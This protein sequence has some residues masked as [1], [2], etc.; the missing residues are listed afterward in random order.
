MTG[1]SVTGVETWERT[2]IYVQHT[3]KSE[4]LIQKMRC[5]EKG[6]LDT[7]IN[8]GF[9]FLSV[10]EK[11]E[12]RLH[13]R[14]LQEQNIWIYGKDKKTKKKKKTLDGLLSAKS[15]AALQRGVVTFGID[16]VMRS[17]P[18]LVLLLIGTRRMRR[19]WRRLWPQFA[20]QVVD[21]RSHLR[22]CWIH[23]S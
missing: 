4:N 22:L 6:S 15:T 2:K 11:I 23:L 13:V 8:Q 21:V 16:E 19:W 5:A 3:V 7:H 17:I 1:A 9:V 10:L 14:L 18:G 20:A 12:H